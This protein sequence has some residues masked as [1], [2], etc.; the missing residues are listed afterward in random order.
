MFLSKKCFVFMVTSFWVLAVSAEEYSSDPSAGDVEFP[1]MTV[2]VSTALSSESRAAYQ[3]A[4]DYEKEWNEIKKKN[5]PKALADASAEEL[6]EIRRCRAEAFRTTTKYK[7]VQEYYPVTRTPRVLA[8]VYTDEFVSK[9]GIAAGNE[10]RIL[11]HL[12]GGAEVLNRRFA[13]YI[14][15]PPIAVVTGIKVISVDY[16]QAPEAIHPAAMEDVIAVYGEL[17]KEYKGENIGIYGCSSGGVFS[18]QSIPWIE[19]AGL[20][21]PGG[22]GVFGH[23]FHLLGSDSSPFGLIYSGLNLPKTK[24]EIERNNRL[25]YFV[26]VDVN[27]PF[28]I[29]GSSPDLLSRFPPTLFI[30]SVRD[31]NLSRAVYSHTQLVKQGVKTELHVWEGLPHCFQNGNPNMA[32]S[33]EFYDVVGDFFDRNLGRKAKVK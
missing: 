6:P 16:R 5:C 15:A 8:G 10:E 14:A 19:K 11:I 33:R 26:D 22:I 23:G 13:G 28:F 12:H 21:K 30:S 18:A 9:A 4:V 27:D 31:Y 25:S 1:A 32:E 17:L 24:K 20:S 29:P 7:D 3:K 2:P